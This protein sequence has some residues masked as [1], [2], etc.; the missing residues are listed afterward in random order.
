[1]KVCSK[2]KELK[3][4]SDFFKDNKAK[5]GHRSACKVCLNTQAREWQSRNRIKTR[6]YSKRCYQKNKHKHRE[7]DNRASREWRSRNKEKV[8]EW[9]RK[10][11][12]NNPEKCKAYQISYRKAN[13]AAYNN[14]EAKRRAKKLKATP[15]WLT[16]LDHEYMLEL[17]KVARELTEQTGIQHEVDHIHPLQGKEVC[18]LHCPDNLQVIPKIENR[19]KSNKLIEEFIHE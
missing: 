6:E 11:R 13:R 15:N 14:A 4:L 12:Q 18:G 1:M 2:C 8:S 3:M 10:W 7:R 17:Y 5:D 16:P 19:K 9:G